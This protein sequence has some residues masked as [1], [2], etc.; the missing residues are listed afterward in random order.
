METH[1]QAHLLSL[2]EQILDPEVRRSRDKVAYLLADSFVEI[3]ASGRQYDKPQILEMLAGEHLGGP[4]ARQEI[5]DFS[6]RWIAADVAMTL[7][8]IVRRS[9]SDGTAAHSLRSSTWKIFDGRWQMIF[10]QGTPTA[11]R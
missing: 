6:A 11:P 7:Y 3:G 1:D 10:H 5:Q 9:P 8:R 4:P 2:E